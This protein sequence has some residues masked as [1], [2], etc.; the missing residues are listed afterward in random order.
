M[1]IVKSTI[2]I[3]W[4]S[5]H[6]KALSEFSCK[7]CCRLFRHLILIVKSLTKKKV[8]LSCQCI[9]PFISHK[10]P[11][12]NGC[13][14]DTLCEA[15]ISVLI[16]LHVNSFFGIKAVFCYSPKVR[17]NRVE[18]FFPKRFQCLTSLIFVDIITPDC[19][20]LES[21]PN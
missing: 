14:F 15:K 8:F 10:S 19:Q 20:A 9:M 17:K 18:K 7:F 13:G 6:F 16:Y 11:R 3:C 12:F 2:P 5:S 4:I 21:I 1:K